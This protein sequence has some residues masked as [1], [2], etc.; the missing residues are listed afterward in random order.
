M[1]DVFIKD[2]LLKGYYVPLRTEIICS[3]KL[4]HGAKILYAA[5]LDYIWALGD[6]SSW[7]SQERLAQDIGVGD[8]T[9]R[10]YF[11]ELKDCGLIEITRRGLSQ[12]NVYTIQP[13]DL[14]RLGLEPNFLSERK[15]SSVQERKQSSEEEEQYEEEEENNN[16]SSSELH[17]N[18]A[19][20]SNEADISGEEQDRLEYVQTVVD[21]YNGQVGIRENLTQKVNRPVKVATLKYNR[22]DAV[23]FWY[24]QGLTV[25]Q[26][27]VRLDEQ[28]GRHSEKEIKGLNYF[29]NALIAMGGTTFKTAPTVTEFNFEDVRDIIEV[30]NEGNGAPFEEMPVPESIEE[31]TGT[32]NK[33]WELALKWVREYDIMA[34]CQ[35]I[36]EKQKQ[37]SKQKNATPIYSLK[38]YANDIAKLTREENDD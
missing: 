33:Q 15:Q 12:T 9:I 23:N 7:P 31:L 34:I 32:E 27:V 20:Q 2:D 4:S 25:K 14:E 13:P 29:K 17:N 28:I 36:R 24:D 19:N 30:H 21:W 3:P 6:K 37:Y 35:V 38:F 8:R 26:V 22:Y 1:S 16:N 11:Q 18:S 10:N 5:V